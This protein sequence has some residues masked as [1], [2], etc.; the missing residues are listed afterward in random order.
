LAAGCWKKGGGS[1]SPP[2]EELEVGGAPANALAIDATISRDT[3]TIGIKNVPTGS[4]HFVCH[5][6]EQ[7]ITPC[8]DGAVIPTPDIAGD[9]KLSVVAKTGEQ[10]VGA[11]ERLLRIDGAYR[12]ERWAVK[13]AN[14]D[15][16]ENGTL[17]VGTDY[18]FKFELAKTAQCPSG[19]KFQCRYD[20]RTSPFW[21]P[22]SDGAF[23]VSGSL[24][25]SGLQHLAAQAVC[26]DEVGPITTVAWYGV[27]KD[28]KPLMLGAIK[29]ANSRYALYLYRAL[30]CPLSQQAFLCGDTA[31][32]ANA[33]TKNLIGPVAAGTVVKLRCG[34][35]TGPALTLG[36]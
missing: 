9:Y 8:H 30:D 27:P 18:V 16:I 29:D 21:V 36:Q 4:D 22:C 35:D 23:K 15:F 24:M 34:D 7:P 33:Q 6:G 11:G 10:V 25:A 3:I 26:G 17:P 12:P 20:S 5:L 2:I 31:C 32:P 13:L 28:Y 14:Q 19:I 1:S